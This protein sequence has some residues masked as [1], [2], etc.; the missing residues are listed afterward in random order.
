[1]NVSDCS[2]FLTVLNVSCP[3]LSFSDIKKVENAL[4]TDATLNTRNA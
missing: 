2:P 3:F 1:M 4:E